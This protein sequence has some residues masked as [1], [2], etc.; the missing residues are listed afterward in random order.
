[1][2]ECVALAAAGNVLETAGFV[3]WTPKTWM[4]PLGWLKHAT[5]D[6]YIQLLE[7]CSH[8]HLYCCDGEAS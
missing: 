5:F 3:D 7:V 4:I 8:F 2:S 6:A 1:M